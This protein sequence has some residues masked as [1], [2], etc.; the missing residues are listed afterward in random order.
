MNGFDTQDHTSKPS[1]PVSQEPSLFDQD[2]S[3]GREAATSREAYAN[4]RK[5]GALNVQA[6]AVLDA[7]VERPDGATTKKLATDTGIGYT[8]VAGRTADLLKMGLLYKTGKRSEGS[9][10]VAAVVNMPEE[11][12]A[13]TRQ[14]VIAL[15]RSHMLGL[16][17]L[18]ITSM[19]KEDK[20]SLNWCLGQLVRECLLYAVEGVLSSTLYRINPKHFSLSSVEVQ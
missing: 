5:S 16:S 8:S 7:Y 11:F 6:R 18:E 17:E 9:A 2:N 14:T 4:L 12:A 20:N 1:R 10:V 19:L 13:K 15:L 3:K